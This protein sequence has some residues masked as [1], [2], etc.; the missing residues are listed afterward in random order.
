MKSFSKFSIYMLGALPSTGQKSVSRPEGC[1]ETTLG[2]DWFRE[3]PVS[4]IQAADREKI[5][6]ATLQHA[7]GTR[8]VV[9]VHDIERHLPIS[10]PHA[11]HAQFRIIEGS[12]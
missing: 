2:Y 12:F 8:N 3:K 5:F 6:K 1:V 11:N 7:V 4:A 10:R 9:T